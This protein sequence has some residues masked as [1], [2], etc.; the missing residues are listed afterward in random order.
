M[1]KV[2][3]SLS[4][5]GCWGNGF[6]N[7]QELSA[8]LAKANTATT[9]ATVDV[10]RGP[11][12][13]II[14]A[15]ERRRAPLPVRLAIET[16]W[17]ATQASHFDPEELISV[18]VSGLGDTQLTDYMC[19]VLATEQKLLSPT[20]FHNSVHNAAAGYWTIS[21]GC[22]KASNSVAGFEDSV[23]IALMEAMIQSAQENQ[24][25]LIT[26][27][28]APTAEIQKDI[29]PHPNEYPFSVSLIIE[30]LR[31]SYDKSHDKSTDKNNNKGNESSILASLEMQVMNTPATWPELQL[32]DTLQEPYIQNPAAKAL[33]LLKVLADKKASTLNLPLSTGSSIQ[34]SI[35]F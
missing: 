33:A 6:S 3:C 30:P 15:N 1:K 2:K 22:M 8:I 13:E 20:K 14:P 23:S 28:D 34:L 27:Y 9:Q 29:Y 32:V 18:F 12:P 17:Q 35:N 31:E 10:A 21:T 24:P 16:S 26:F 7:W 25:V 19:K 11:K 5:I 4:A